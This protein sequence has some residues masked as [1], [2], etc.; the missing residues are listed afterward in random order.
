MQTLKSETA[1]V[2]C[3]AV[4]AFHFGEGPWCIQQPFGVPPCLLV[5]LQ[6]LSDVDDLPR[7]Y[8]IGAV[9]TP[10][11]L[12]RALGQRGMSRLQIRVPQLDLHGHIVRLDRRHPFEARERRRGASGALVGVR[13]LQLRGGVGAIE[14]HGALEP[15]YLTV[16]R[17]LESCQSASE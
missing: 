11:A 1:L 14:I 10:R 6:L 13:Q 9:R 17:S 4:A 8:E 15:E 5:L 2:R 3:D 16:G 12:Q 7:E